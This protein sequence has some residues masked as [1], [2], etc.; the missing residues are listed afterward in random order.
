MCADAAK[1]SSQGLL[2]GFSNAGRQRF[3][4]ATSSVY[5]CLNRF[6]KL[7]D[8]GF[9]RFHHQ[10]LLFLLSLNLRGKLYLKFFLFLLLPLHCGCRFHVQSFLFLSLCLE[11]YDS[12]HSL[13]DPVSL[14]LQHTNRGD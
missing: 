2:H 9:V 10:L 8:T 5:A 11:G 7:S 6:R 4:I 14:L 12:G 1:I 13:G 3:S